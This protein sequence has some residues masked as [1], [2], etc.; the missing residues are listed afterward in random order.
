MKMKIMRMKKMNKAFN[1]YNQLPSYKLV[2]VIKDCKTLMRARPEHSESLR[3][4]IKL[5]SGILISRQ[6]ID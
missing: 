4:T 2:Q 1:Q 6:V 5:I 3:N